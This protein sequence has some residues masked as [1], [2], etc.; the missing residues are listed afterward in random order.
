MTI[1]HYSFV[2]TECLVIKICRILFIV[3]VHYVNATKLI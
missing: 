3:Y 1:K 2:V